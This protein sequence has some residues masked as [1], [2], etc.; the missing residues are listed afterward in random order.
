MAMINR[1][2]PAGLIQVL[3]NREARQDERDDAAMDLESYP[4]EDVIEALLAI[5]SSPGEDEELVASCLESLGGI[6]A[7]S[8]LREG[9]L[10]RL[11]DETSRRFVAQVVRAK[12]NK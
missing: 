6:W 4:E 11:P 7:A 9:D 5:I 12:R 8:G 2:Q 10:G 1:E 3:L